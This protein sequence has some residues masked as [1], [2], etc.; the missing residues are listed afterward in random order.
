MS[1]AKA[2]ATTMIALRDVRSGDAMTAPETCI[3]PHFLPVS[4]GTPGKTHQ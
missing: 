2:R 4:W 3:S 1:K